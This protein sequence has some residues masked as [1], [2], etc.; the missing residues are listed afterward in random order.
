MRI[1]WAV[2]ASLDIDRW[3]PLDRHRLH[4]APGAPLLTI[5]GYFYRCSGILCT[6]VYRISFKAYL[7]IHCSLH[8]SF[9]VYVAVAKYLVTLAL[10]MYVMKLLCQ[11]RTYHF[12]AA[13]GFAGFSR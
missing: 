11:L 4:V 3:H 1:C 9:Y 2:W 13:A 5:V 8:V 12:V 6:V 7:L 10:R